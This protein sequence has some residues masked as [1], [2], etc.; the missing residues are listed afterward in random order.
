MAEFNPRSI[1]ECIDNKATQFA[2]IRE[3]IEQNMENK[4]EDNST[5]NTAFNNVYANYKKLF[6]LV[7]AA[8]P[9]IKL[10]A[11]TLVFHSN[12]YLAKHLNYFEPL[13][14]NMKIQDI[15]TYRNKQAT[16]PLPFTTIYP[17]VYCNLTPAGNQYVG[18]NMN[19]GEGVYSSK[20][21]IHFIQFPY[22]T[23]RKSDG[24]EGTDHLKD[25]F[26][27]TSTQFFK[28]YMEKKNAE[29][30]LDPT[31]PHYCGFILSTEVD[32]TRD[33]DSNATRFAG[34]FNADYR[35]YPELL[36]MDG[37]DK[38]T[39]VAQYDLYRIDPTVTLIGTG[40]AKRRLGYLPTISSIDFITQ[41]VNF[42]EDNIEDEFKIPRLNFDVQIAS[43]NSIGAVRTALDG[44]YGADAG[45]L[46]AYV[47]PSA[48]DHKLFSLRDGSPN[49]L[50][51]EQVAYSL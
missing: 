17:R 21:A 19:V 46:F 43:L 48:P 32:A 27:I 25:L 2:S 30:L 14:S 44:N 31:K 45:K 7:F 22:I 20:E 11:H 16:I 9:A 39:K 34:T 50:L 3:L 28:Q 6:D 33:K 8:Y 15:R 23:Y 18:A 26:N 51:F 36:I 38:F 5:S 40:P 1:Q 29:A 10:P 47:C 35:I 41:I 37:F 13:G 49:E 4:K 12:Q 24:S 42:V